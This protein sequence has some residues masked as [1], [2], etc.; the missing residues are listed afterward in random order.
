MGEHMGNDIYIKSYLV[1]ER[2]EGLGTLVEIQKVLEQLE[3]AP[4]SDIEGTLGLLRRLCE[5]TGRDPADI[6]EALHILH[7]FKELPPK[8]LEESHRLQTRLHELLGLPP[9]RLYVPTGR[10]EAEEETR[11]IR[12]GR[13]LVTAEEAY[14]P[15]PGKGKLP[16]GFEIREGVFIGNW[17]ETHVGLRQLQPHDVIGVEDLLSDI[18]DEIAEDNSGRA[19][20]RGRVELLD[21]LARWYDWVEWEWEKKT[22][23]YR[24]KGKLRGE[25]RT[26]K[27]PINY[28][29]RR[30]GTTCGED[31]CGAC[32]SGDPYGHWRGFCVDV[33]VDVWG[34][35]FN[36][37]LTFAEIIEASVNAKL[38]RCWLEDYGE[39][40][41]FRPERFLLPQTEDNN[42]P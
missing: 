35:R 12:F 38:V 24:E 6:D 2:T 36:P 5:L 39:W 37:R 20:M 17:Y 4:S 40:W 33:Q 31:N 1:G 15:P 13:P 34:G 41:H 28:S 23:D 21:A 16:T 30:L 8:S 29:Y 25:P 18:P 10:E 26:A 27:I 9:P 19:D 14:P 22:A 42:N 7:R 3:Q 11:M 32:D